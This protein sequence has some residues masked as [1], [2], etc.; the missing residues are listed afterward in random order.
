MPQY[1][2]FYKMFSYLHNDNLEN[3]RFP[4]HALQWCSVLELCECRG[5]SVIRKEPLFSLISWLTLFR[6]DL[7]FRYVFHEMCLCRHACT[8][9]L[10]ES[11]IILT[12]LSFYST[13]WLA[14]HKTTLRAD[15]KIHLGKVW[16]KTYRGKYKLLVMSS[17]QIQ[18][19]RAKH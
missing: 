13:F 11:N 2:F 4:L 17:G 9:W 6:V 5:T 14:V 7:L 1:S 8:A 19:R 10:Y 12:C 18:W 15:H 3:W 16:L